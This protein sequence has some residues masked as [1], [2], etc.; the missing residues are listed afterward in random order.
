MPR[1]QNKTS[2][3]RDH[4]LAA[5]GG[6]PITMGHLERD[7]KSR[8]TKLNSRRFY[9]ALMRVPAVRYKGEKD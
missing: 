7:R 2:A 4:R 5:C 1:T 9:L 6:P 8:E 3:G